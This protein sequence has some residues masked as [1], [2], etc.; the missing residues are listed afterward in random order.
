[1]FLCSAHDGNPACTTEVVPVWGGF[2]DETSVQ[3]GHTFTPL[4]ANSVCHVCHAP[5][6]HCEEKDW[7]SFTSRAA[8]G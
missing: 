2:C 4:A 8:F 1:M 5:A 3:F 6:M 7:F